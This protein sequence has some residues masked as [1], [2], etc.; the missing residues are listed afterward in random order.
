MRLTIRTNLA[1][2]VLMCCAANAG[3][4]LRSADIAEACNA[5]GNHLAQ[6][7]NQLQINGFVATQRG[8]TGG[9]QLSRPPEEISIG[10][11]FRI[12]ESGVPFA[13]CF[14]PQTNTCPLISACRL[15]TYISRAVEAFYAELD[16]VTLQDLV[17]DNCGLTQ[18]L[19]LIPDPE[20]MRCT[21]KVA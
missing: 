8:R 14:N 1:A 17:Q 2:R 13:E 12:F 20:S 21:R 3:R 6:V 5:S 18:I 4:T 10:A 16:P 11:V 9:L 19:S 15:R 7:I